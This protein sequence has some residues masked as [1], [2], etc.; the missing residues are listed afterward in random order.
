MAPFL[1]FYRPSNMVYL[2][3]E[4]VPVGIF[5]TKPCSRQ[6]LSI[7]PGASVI[8]ESHGFIYDSL[9]Y[10]VCSEAVADGQ[11]DGGRWF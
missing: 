4:Y 10:V 8:K 7:S 9:R 11:L 5:L 2:P 6:T 3:P 1:S